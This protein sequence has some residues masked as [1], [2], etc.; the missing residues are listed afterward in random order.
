MVVIAREKKQGRGDR[1][2]WGGRGHDLKSGEERGVKQIAFES[3][4][5]GGGEVT[6]RIYGRNSA[7]ARVWGCW[8][9]SRT[10]QAIV[11]DERE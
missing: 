8:K 1:I 11:A 3:R 5:E 7:P 6:P 2:C 10:K 9:C 4:L